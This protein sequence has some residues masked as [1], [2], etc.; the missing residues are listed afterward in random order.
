MFK[1]VAGILLLAMLYGCGAGGFIPNGPHAMDQAVLQQIVAAESAR[2]HV[3]P[4]LVRAI[5]TVESHGDPSAISRAGAQ[6][7]MQL[8]P[9]TSATYGIVNPFDPG[10]NVAAGCRYLHDLLAR[11]RNSVP[12]A[13]AAYNAGPGA[14]DASGGVPP[15]AETRAYVSR[16][17]AS[18]R[19]PN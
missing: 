19:S 17:T 7:L 12:L 6:G 15:F 4:R 1:P 10:S 14:V 11:Y 18:L 16:V 3:S 8:M 9:E 13:V 5:I 2:S